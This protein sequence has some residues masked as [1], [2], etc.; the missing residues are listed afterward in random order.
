[1]PI[2][3]R[4]TMQ[5]APRGGYAVFRQPGGIATA[6]ID[7]TTGLMA[8]ED[9]PRTVTEVYPAGKVPGEVCDSHGGWWRDEERLDRRDVD[10]EEEERE[11]VHPFRRWL[12]DVFGG[13][14]DEDDDG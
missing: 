1:L 4:F 2:W 11:R 6:V 3:S 8:T 12:R 14:D 9:C 5:V 13:G 7:P 10:D